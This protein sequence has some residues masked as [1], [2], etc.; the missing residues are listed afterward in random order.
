MALVDRTGKVI[1]V[2]R[3]E[4][5]NGNRRWFAFENE[6]DAARFRDQVAESSTIAVR[7]VQPIEVPV[8]HFVEEPAAE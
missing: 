5:A 4:Y 1:W 3:V 6:A 7:R 2:M 8:Y